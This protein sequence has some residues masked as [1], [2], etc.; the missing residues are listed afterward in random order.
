MSKKDVK[1][2]DLYIVY[3]LAAAVQ[4]F[5]DSKID[6]EKEDAERIGVIVGSGVGGLQTDRKSVV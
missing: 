5:E 2:N 6:M 3:A 1:R 4:A